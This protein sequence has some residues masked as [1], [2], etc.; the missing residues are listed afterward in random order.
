MLLHHRQFTHS[1]VFLAILAIPLYF[2]SPLY[3]CFAVL[4]FLSHLLLDYSF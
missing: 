3:A 4:G 2:F 1:I